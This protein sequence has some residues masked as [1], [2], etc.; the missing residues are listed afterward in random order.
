[1]IVTRKF[2]IAGMQCSRC[3]TII[4]EAVNQIDGVFFIKTDY[5]KATLKVRF[6]TKKTSLA[7]IQKVCSS[8]GYTFNVTPESQKQKILKISLSILAF[9]ALIT[10]LLLARKFGQ[11]FKLPE[12][13]SKISNGMIFIV[14]L[15]TGFHCVGMCGSFLIGYTAKDAEQ[16]RS[17]FRSHILYSAGKT[18]SY[19]MFGALFGFIG[20]L[21]RISPFISGLSISIAGAFLILYGLNMLN[22]FRYL[23]VIRIKQPKAITRY[24]A[25]RNRQSRG[26]FFIGFFSGFILGCGPLQVMYVMA[27]GIGNAL[28]GA[29]ILTLFGLGTLPALLGFGLLTRILSDKMTRNFIHASGI[30]LIVLGSMMLNRGF[31]QTISG[32]DLKSVPPCCQKQIDRK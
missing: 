19:A 27:A 8:R 25:K 31:M 13:N 26:P 28:E 14:G 12:I 29:K 11:Q 23:K 16:G 1:M 24:L 5:L 4:E 22:I 2:N 15:L 30:I 21:F 6:D 20:S 18:L 32:N 10:I 9:A 3:E 7:I 17:L